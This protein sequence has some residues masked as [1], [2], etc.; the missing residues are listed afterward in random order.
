MKL[1]TAALSMATAAL[2]AT[3]AEPTFADDAAELKNPLEGQAEAI[4]AGKSLYSNT[5][6]FCHGPN[7]LGARAPNLVEGLFRPNG[8]ADDTIVFDIILKGRPGT[9]M[10]GFEGTYTETEIWQVISYLRQEG[11]ARAKPKPTPK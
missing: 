6:L 3:R 11:I 5:C 2:L 10:G 9:L 8:G 1:L 7:G 4:E